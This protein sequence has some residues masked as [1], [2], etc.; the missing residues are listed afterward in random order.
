MKDTP[1]AAKT[2]GDY[3]NTLARGLSFLRAFTTGGR[4]M[5]LVA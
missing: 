3:L 4:E 2:D 1:K 5:T